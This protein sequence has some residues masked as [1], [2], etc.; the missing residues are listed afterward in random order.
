M[1]LIEL[2]QELQD[3]I[4]TFLELKEIVKLERICHSMN[5]LVS[6]SNI[7]KHLI[8]KRIMN[9]Y[10]LSFVIDLHYKHYLSQFLNFKPPFD[11]VLLRGVDQSSLDHRTQSI[12]Q[13][14]QTNP[15]TFWSSKGSSNPDSD[16]YLVFKLSSSI[17]VVNSIQIKPFRAIFQRNR[18]IYPP[19]QFKISVGN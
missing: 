14:I 10:Y 6:N 1:L 18:P 11:N 9:K 5:K 12:D 2:P 17:T 16:E 7:Y 13:A 8:K 15:E 3:L 4:F 19:K